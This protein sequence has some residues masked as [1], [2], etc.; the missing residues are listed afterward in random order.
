MILMLC[1]RAC[2]LAKCFEA[3][4]RLRRIGQN[5]KDVHCPSVQAPGI[6]WSRNQPCV[7]S[8]YVF[9]KFNNQG[10]PAWGMY[11]DGCHNKKHFLWNKPEEEGKLCESKNFRN[12]SRKFPKRVELMV[13]ETAAAAMLD[14]PREVY[15]N[16][17]SSWRSCRSG[18]D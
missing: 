4:M 10:E 2:R 14:H 7:I 12:H 6:S 9:S 15:H 16:F 18:N 13:H 3:G 17:E 11:Q 8:A 5:K 1:Y